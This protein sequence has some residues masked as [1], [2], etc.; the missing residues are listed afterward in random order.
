MRNFS[1]EIAIPASRQ[2]A[3]ERLKT[4]RDHLATAEQIAADRVELKPQENST[5]SWT[6]NLVMTSVKKDREDPV[7][8]SHRL[9]EN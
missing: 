9:R 5:E 3:Q 2:V 6:V 4:V 8:L 7:R 1:Y